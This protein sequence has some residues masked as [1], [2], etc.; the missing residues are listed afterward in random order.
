MNILKYEHESLEQFILFFYGNIFLEKL[1]TVS[2]HVTG[3][4]LLF[5]TRAGSLMPTGTSTTHRLV[6]WK[7]QHIQ[8]VI[9]DLLIVY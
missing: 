6:S 2:S 5:E 8:V 1:G 3:L 7:K 4:P 9:N